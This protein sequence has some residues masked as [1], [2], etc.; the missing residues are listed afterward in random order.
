MR[1]SFD[2]S[3]VFR[4]S[5]GFDRI[6][7]MLEGASRLQAIDTWPPYDI[8]KTGD[9][10]YRITMEVAGYGPQHL[11]LTQDGNLLIVSGSKPAEDGVQYLHR[12]MCSGEFLRRFELADHVKV[13]AANLE[14][15]L[16][17]IDL[18]LKL[19]EEMKPRRI[20]IRSEA[21]G[22]GQPQIEQKSKA[23]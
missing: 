7:D 15:G 9:E 16:L 4:S 23:A 21:S 8:V 22:P 11:N 17:T 19:P 2:F 20:A 10:A 3:P 18:A 5:I 1:T 14:N 13:A 12:G 6:F